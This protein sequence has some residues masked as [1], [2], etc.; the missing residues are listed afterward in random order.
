MTEKELKEEKREFDNFYLVRPI[1]DGMKLNKYGLPMLR[2][3]HENEV[4]IENLMPINF[5][6]LR[7]NG[8]YHNNLVLNFRDDKGLDRQW[9]NSLEYIPLLTGCGAVCTLD[10]SI[11]PQMPPLWFN[12]YLFRSAYTGSLWQLHT[13]KVVPSIPWCSPDTYDIA[14]SFVEPGGIVIV[15]SLGSNTHPDTFLDGFNAM[16]YALN[17][18]L[19]IVYGDFIKGMSGRFMHIKYEEAFDKK[20]KTVEDISLFPLEKIFMREAC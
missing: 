8:D 18:S 6:N 9:N 13:V 16:K 7:K 4:D 10:Y 17:P 11:S 2:T 12:Q 19:I 20:A 5:Q 15:S 14:F 3:L 1:L